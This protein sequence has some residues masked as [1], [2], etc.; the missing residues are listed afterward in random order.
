MFFTFSGAENESN[1][2]NIIFMILFV[3]FQEMADLELLFKK[4]F[5][6]GH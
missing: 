3:C 5:E 6:D 1:E 2:N 4:V